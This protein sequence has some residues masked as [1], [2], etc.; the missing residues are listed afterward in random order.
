M[1]KHHQARANLYRR[2]A[3]S[4]SAGIPLAQSIARQGG[5]DAG[6]LRP[7]SDAIGAGESAGEAFAAL[8]GISPLEAK[9]IKAG[10][11]A[12]ALPD[13]FNRLASLHEERLANKRQLIVSLAY[14]V[15][16]LHAA[17]VLPALPALVRQGGGLSAFLMEGLGPL[18]AG[19]VALGVAWVGLTFARQLQLPALEAIELAL[20]LWGKYVKLSEWGNGFRVCG[21]L[22]THGVGVLEATQAASQAATRT[23]FADAWRHIEARLRDGDSLAQACSSV[24][25]FPTDALDLIQTGETSGQLD[26]S[27]GQLERDYEGRRTMQ[28]RLLIGAAA[29][30]AF[31]LA[32]CMVAY[33]VI[34]FYVGHLNQALDVL[35]P[36]TTRPR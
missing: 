2:L 16:L 6:L 1:L 27:L 11:R 24:S 7:V 33:T 32:A 5:S 25:D 29:T 3:V 15:L 13:V 9:A 17:C 34:S 19:Y 23:L 4:Q 21:L 31:L 12:G 20:P 28:L 8:P 14:P 26:T 36:R 18:V 22:Y 35:N 30:G 10:D